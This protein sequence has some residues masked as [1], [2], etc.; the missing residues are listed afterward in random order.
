[1]GKHKEIQ[2]WAAGCETWGE[3]IIVVQGTLVETDKQFRVKEQKDG[4]L[5][6]TERQFSTCAGYQKRWSKE[7]YPNGPGY[8]TRDGAL[9]GHL[10][11]L[12]KQAEQ[13]RKVVRARTRD[14][15]NM[16]QQ[17]RDKCFKEIK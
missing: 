1:M 12:Q 6:A 10:K 5:N 9:L 11:Y 17:M 15:V 14:V 13:A 4:T 16:E 7:S 3:Q 2:R 8:L